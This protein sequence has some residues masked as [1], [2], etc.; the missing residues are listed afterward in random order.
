MRVGVIGAGPAGLTAAFALSR[1]GIDVEVFEAGSRVGGMARSLDLWGHR[2][3]LGPHRFFSRDARV[4]RTWLDIL[5]PN[6]RMIERQ[7]RI[8]YRNQLF[9][10]PLRPGNALARM[11]LT[12]ASLCVLSYA[13]ARLTASTTPAQT[14]EDWVVSRFGRRLY[15]MFFKTYSE[16]LWGI[17]CHELS[18][19]FAAQRIKKFSLGQA[20][21]A[22]TGFARTRH[23]TLA[24]AFAYPLAGNGDVYERMASRLV[25]TGG[26]LSLGRRV[27]GVEVT[28]GRATGIRLEDGGTVRCDHVVSTM[29]LN[30]LVQGLEAAPPAVKAAAAQLKFRNTILVYLLVKREDLFS[31][32]WLY[33]HSPQLRMGRVTNFRNWAPELH[34]GLSSSVLALEY[35]CND[36]EELW[37]ETEDEL[38]RRGTDEI[39]ATGLVQR[40]DVL[41]GKIVRVPR[42]YPVYTRNYADTLTPIVTFLKTIP[43][44]WPLGRYG[45]FKY[46]NQDH[47]ILMGLLAAENIAND[48]QHDLWALNS[49]DEYQEG[50]AITE[51][52]LVIDGGGVAS[53]VV[54]NQG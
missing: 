33:V 30:L 49:D 37:H 44:L 8:L 45:S 13:R 23:R 38:V 32:Q 51:S 2:V 16:K 40:A 1:S 12:E 4:N 9:D 29:P 31:D 46:N 20:L 10:Y 47:S 26:K 54:G 35:W 24:D 43:N 28:T 34:G 3:D 21:T 41:E 27:A 42:C 48:A 7:T 11:G 14:F 18:A 17:P 5:G 53:A 52:G 50:S 15:G 6:Y 22:M 25:A 19:D 36:E 39:V